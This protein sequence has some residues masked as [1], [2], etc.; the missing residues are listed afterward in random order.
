MTTRVERRI[1]LF[2]ADVQVAEFTVRPGHSIEI[3]QSCV[4]TLT[5]EA[6]RELMLQ[7]EK[8]YL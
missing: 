5:I 7:I 1:K 6:L 3:D 8:E 4:V 2:E